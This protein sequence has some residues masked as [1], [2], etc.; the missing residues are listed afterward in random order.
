MEESSRYLK[1]GEELG[2]EQGGVLIAIAGEKVYAV[3][4]AAYY[5]WRMC[6]GSTTVG[7][8][9]DDIVSSTKL[10][11]EDVKAAV[12]TI[13]QQLLSAGLVKPAEEPSS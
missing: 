13:I 12:S 9:I 11:R 3:T 4:P 5:V 1:Q 8:I 7:Q 2:V 6:D 10:S